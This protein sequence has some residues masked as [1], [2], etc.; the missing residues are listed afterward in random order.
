MTNASNTVPDF[1]KD[2]S[3]NLDHEI[4]LDYFLGWTLRCAVNTNPDLKLRN[5]SKKILSFLLFKGQEM[6]EVKSVETWKQWKRM[7]LCAEVVINRNGNDEE[8]AILFENKMYTHTHSNQL[9]RYKE[10]F[11]KFYLNKNNDTTKYTTKYFF[12]TCLYKEADYLSD[13]IECEK[14]GFDFLSFGWI[15]TNS[16]IVETGNYLFDEFWFRYW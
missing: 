9:E 14:V 8:Y 10:I 1:F 2:N 4:M 13:K 6:F 12:L 3:E 11:E 16:E 5:E 15:K 7:D